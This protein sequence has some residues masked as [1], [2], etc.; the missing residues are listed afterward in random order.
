MLLASSARSWYS[1]PC[2]RPMPATV[3]ERAA[4]SP[5]RAVRNRPLVR[6]TAVPRPLV[7]RTRAADQRVARAAATRHAAR[8]VFARHDTAH[9]HVV[10]RPA[11]SR[12]AAVDR[13]AAVVGRPAVVAAT[14]ERSKAAHRPRSM[15][16]RHRRRRSSRLANEYCFTSAVWHGLLVGR[17]LAT[18]RLH[19]QQVGRATTR[20]HQ[21]ATY[22][23][24][25]LEMCPFGGIASEIRL[26]HCAERLPRRPWLR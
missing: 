14:A 10:R 20:L 25:S 6:R 5:R 16:K 17:V 7:A 24:G 4:A 13:T 22:R 11:V 1:A 2:S 23:A 3:V 15:S 8:H 26:F 21:V 18:S 19:G 9:G 12:P